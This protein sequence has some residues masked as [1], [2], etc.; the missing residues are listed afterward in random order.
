MLD[1]KGEVKG[2]RLAGCAAAV[3]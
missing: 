1:T 3:V 2:L